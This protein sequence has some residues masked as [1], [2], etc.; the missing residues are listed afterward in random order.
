MTLATHSTTRQKQLSAKVIFEA[1]SQELKQLHKLVERL[2]SLPQ[3][4]IEWHLSVSSADASDLQSLDYIS[5]SL[6]I[7]STVLDDAAKQS[8]IKWGFDELKSVEESKLEDLKSR[9][10]GTDNQTTLLKSGGGCE[11]F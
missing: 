11:F 7:L 5:Q 9:F 3:L 10:K 8:S 2:Q 1:A 4:N 6:T